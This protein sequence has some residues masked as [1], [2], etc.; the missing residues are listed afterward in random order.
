MLRDEHPAPDAELPNT[1]V[2]LEIERLLSPPFVK[3][4]TYG[5]RCSTIIIIDAAGRVTL[6][7]RS[8]APGGGK[9]APTV[10]LDL[11]P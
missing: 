11:E 10:E 3:G 7:E 1:G 2:P 5:T 9:Q 4:D 8:F 6:S